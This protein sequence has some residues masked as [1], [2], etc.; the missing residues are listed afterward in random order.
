[1][2][3]CSCWRRINE[4]ITT[5]DTKHSGCGR[6]DVF[7]CFQWRD[8]SWLGYR[9]EEVRTVRAQDVNTND[10][11]SCPCVIVFN[12]QRRFQLHWMFYLLSTAVVSQSANELFFSPDYH[13]P[14]FL[15]LN[16]HILIFMK[17]LFYGC[18][19]IYEIQ[20]VDVLMRYVYCCSFGPVLFTF[21]STDWHDTCT[22]INVW[23]YADDATSFA[24]AWLNY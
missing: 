1:M 14:R 8:E 7:V 4:R 18:N 24:C 11:G 9:E 2:T 21:Y 17:K 23:M 5:V 3:G 13:Y 20:C 12:T 22:E 19:H 10:G 16:Y 6:N 15:Y